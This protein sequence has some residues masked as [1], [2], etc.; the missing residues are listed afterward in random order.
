MD[1]FTLIA[2]IIAWFTVA[3]AMALSVI[4]IG[5]FIKQKKAV[6]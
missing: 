2:T 5:L 6:E 3:T 1:I 4:L